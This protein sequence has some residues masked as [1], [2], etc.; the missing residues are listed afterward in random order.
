MS[1]TGSAVVAEAP[2]ARSSPPR[3]W[4][5]PATARRLGDEPFG[6]GG[7]HRPDAGRS[8]CAGPGCGQR[9]GERLTATT[10]PT[11]PAP[12][13]RRQRGGGHAGAAVQRPGGAAGGG[14]GDGRPGAGA[15]SATVALGVAAGAQETHLI[16][17]STVRRGRQPQGPGD[18]PFG[19]GGPH[20]PDAGRS[21]CAGPGCGQRLGERLTATTSPTWPALTIAGSAEAGTL[22]RLFSDLEGRW[23]RGR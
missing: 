9:L 14:A 8:G 15:W 4:M 16:T 1:A 3:R 20:R 6:D 23:G 18:E 5:R 21:E 7:P 22:V 11:W 2:D 12:H 10:S 17:A 19:D 13:H